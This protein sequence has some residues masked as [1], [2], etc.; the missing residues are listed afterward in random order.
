MVFGYVRSSL[1]MKVEFKTPDL[2][3]YAHLSREG[4]TVERANKVC[5]KPL[6]PQEL[7]E[8]KR[9]GETINW[10]G[11]NRSL[12]AGRG[13]FTADGVCHFYGPT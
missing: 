3:I 1:T 6:W 9:C 4:R 13:A 11:G 10:V 8:F 5:P 7:K 12:G 2:R